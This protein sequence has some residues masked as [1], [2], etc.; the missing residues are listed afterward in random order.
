MT[1]SVE[2]LA[3]VLGA[4]LVGMSMVLLPYGLA[5]AAGAMVFI[6]IEELV[7]ECQRCGH[8]DAAVLAAII[9]FTVM[10]VLDIALG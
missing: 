10:T 7:P 8:A 9:G 5:F 2:P 6:V 4:A 3:A 1:G